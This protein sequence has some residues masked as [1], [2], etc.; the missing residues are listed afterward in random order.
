MVCSPW[1]PSVVA[2][3]PGT[4]VQRVLS[5]GGVMVHPEGAAIG[6]DGALYVVDPDAG[7]G[8]RGL[9]LRIDPS[10]G[11]QTVVCASTAFLDPNGIVAD[12]DG[13]LLVADPDAFSTP[14]Q[15]GPG[16][17]FRVWPDTGAVQVVSS[18][19]LLV[20][21][22]GLTF[23]P[24]RRIMVAD[25]HLDGSGGVVKV[26]PLTGA[27]QRVASGP[28]FDFP[29]GVATEAAGT[30]VVSNFAAA[31][32][33]DLVRVNPTTGVV[34]VLASDFHNPAGV[35][36]EASGSIVTSDYR[37][38]T[39]VRVDPASGAET[40]VASGPPMVVPDSGGQPSGPFGICAV[41]AFADFSAHLSIRV[42]QQ[43]APD[44]FE[45]N[46]TFAL[47]ATSNGIS[48]TREVVT[49]RVGECSVTVPA[50]AFRALPHDRYQFSGPLGG[51]TVVATIERSGTSWSYRFTANGVD[52]GVLPDPVPVTLF[53]GDEGGRSEVEP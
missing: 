30:L 44:A 36:V 23:D 33:G 41:P 53:I 52:L 4:G 46:G 40:T 29:V 39:V 18:L 42:P 35:A 45:V 27:Q 26:D 9:V 21:P 10:S 47:A 8:G 43:H 50:G 22:F 25:G 51:G 7:S 11:A 6:M 48:P 34:T 28:L 13:T 1:A 5:T 12:T 37:G 38:G 3:D 31:A 16:A 15:A 2:V 14:P 20:Y 49:A 17:V 19:G 32:H 24:Q